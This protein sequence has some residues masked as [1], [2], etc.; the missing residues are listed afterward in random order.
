MPMTLV[1]MSFLS[2][3]IAAWIDVGTGT[4]FLVPLVLL[5][6]ASVLYWHYTEL[7]GAGD[8]RLYG[9]VQFYPMI[10]IPLIFLWFASPAN[11]KGLYLL[12]WVIAWYGVAKLFELFDKNIYAATGFISGHSLKHI[13]A[14]IATWYIVR[15]FEKK[16]IAPD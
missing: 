9:F 15:F 3:T 6:V 2:A 8:L 16:Y 1:F 10:I 5:G 13:A 11:N 4:R 14:A 7:K 12:I